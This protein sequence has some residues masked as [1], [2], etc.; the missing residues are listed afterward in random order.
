MAGIESSF[1]DLTRFDA[2]SRL[3]TPIHRLE[4]RVKVLTT[5]VFIVAVVSFDK[6][7]LSA[8]LPFVLY[9][10]V[11]ITL[12]DLPLRYLAGKVFLALPF[13]F[14][15]GVFNPF[16]DR[17]VLVRFGPVGVSGGWISFASILIRFVLTVTAA[18]ALVATTGMYDL[19][20]ALDRLGVPRA[21]TVQ[22][23]FLYRYLFVL[24]DE[25]SR[26]HRAR[27]LRSFGNR[28]TGLRV[29]SHM[30]GQLLL[31]T[32]D[33]AQ[34]IHAAMLCR[35]FDGELRQA[36]SSSIG[37]RDILFFCGWTAAFTLMRI[38]D[39]PAWAGKIATGMVR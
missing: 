9:P 17:E 26:M 27:S 16:F 20:H 34:R 8:L 3:D 15:I 22:L 19:C 24:V 5:M 39:L 37:K 25:G 2:L 36:R 33:R 18:L 6:Y 10:V 31:R 11:L 4:P 1:F 29:Y 38:Y 30:I 12:G 32:L 7:R 21:L 23:L 14:F 28:G 35:G 13:A